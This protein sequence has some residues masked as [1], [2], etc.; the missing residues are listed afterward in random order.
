M[1]RLFLL[2]FVVVCAT[3]A[4]WTQNSLIATLSHNGQMRAFYGQSALKE[5][6]AAAADGDVLTLSSGTFLATDITKAITLRGAGMLT[7]YETQTTPSYISGSFIINVPDTIHRLTIE[8]INQIWSSSEDVTCRAAINPVFTKCKFNIIDDYDPFSLKNATFVNCYITVEV[9]LNYGGNS[10]T[11]INCYVGDPWYNINPSSVLEMHNCVIRCGNCNINSGMKS[12]TFSNCVFV[13]NY[14]DT[15][16][17]LPGTNMAYN[18]V[19][20]GNRTNIFANVP[21][22]TNRVV[23]S[24]SSIFKEY[25]GGNYR[26]EI[27]F[28]LTDEAI[29]N[30]LG[31]DGTQVG[32]FGGSLPFDPTVSSLQITKCNVAGKSTVDGKLSVD[33]EVSGIE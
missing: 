25:T 23:E 21:N 19:F 3:C 24:V 4:A 33:I 13:W 31:T 30:Y 29:T 32:M 11:F 2:L 20:T 26:D 22:S 10:C 28:A 18:C 14:N 15:P 27:S 7:D 17:S 8:G 5:A 6:H 16:Y 9:R 12:S 1:K